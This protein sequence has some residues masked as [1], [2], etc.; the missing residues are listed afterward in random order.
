MVSP[1]SHVWQHL[2]FSDFSL[3]TRPQYYLVVDKDVKR[4]IIQTNKQT[5]S[6]PGLAKPVE[7]D[8]VEFN[9]TTL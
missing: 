2:K 3:G 8:L 6:H 9:A 1:L 7:F 5:S 4:P